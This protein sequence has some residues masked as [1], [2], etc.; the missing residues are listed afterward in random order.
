MQIL[1]KE[2]STESTMDDDW[3]SEGMLLVFTIFYKLLFRYT[4]SRISDPSKNVDVIG[5]AR[6]NTCNKAYI[7]VWKKDAY[8]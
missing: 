6:S 5:N 1:E 8:G 3:Y 7:N 2:A 4:F